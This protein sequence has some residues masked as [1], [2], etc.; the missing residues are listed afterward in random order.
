MNP[1]CA[2]PNIVSETPCDWNFDAGVWL[3]ACLQRLGV[4]HFVVSPGSRS[5]P[6]ALG[7]WYCAPTAYTVIVDE[8]SAGFYALGRVKAGGAP[9]RKSV[10]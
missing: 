3:V 2:Q 5:T 7:V 9:D 10:V 4:R 8:R 6:L 1:S